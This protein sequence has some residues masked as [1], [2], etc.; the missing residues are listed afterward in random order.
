MD[1]TTSVSNIQIKTTESAQGDV[2]NSSTLT[3]EPGDGA[4]FRA[5]LERQL[6]VNAGQ[7]ADGKVGGVHAPSLADKV[8]TRTTDLAGEIKKDQ[9]HVSQMLEQATRNG[10]SIPLVKAMMALSDYQMRVQFVA[11]TASK[12]VSSLDSLTKLQ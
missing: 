10:D 8:M 12:A 5:A 7:K 9:L 4:E 11:K 2:A 1:A 3:L 6:N